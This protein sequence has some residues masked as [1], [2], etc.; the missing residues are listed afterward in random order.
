MSTAPLRV[1]LLGL[2]GFGNTVL[3]AL[4]ADAR[5]RVVAVFTHRYDG[6]FPYYDE[7][8]L[9]DCCARHGVTC[10]HDVTVGSEAG[11]QRMRSA[12]PDVV[13]V[14]TFKD[15]LREAVLS[16]PRLGVVNLHPSLL[17]RHRGPCPT[18]A[19]LLAGDAWSGVTAH[20]AGSGVDDG[21]I[22][23][24][25]RV[26][27]ADVPTDG[28]L[29]RRLAAVAAAMVPDLISL[30]QNGARP[31]GAPQDPSHATHA[32]RPRPED[33]F[34]ELV[35]SADDLCRRVRALTPLPGTSIA[36]GSGRVPVLSC[37]RLPGSAAPVSRD[38]GAIDVQLGSEAV[39][40]FTSRSDR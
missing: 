22:I 21:D 18:Q 7:Q 40:L 25:R 27:I 12:S 6:P 31:A 17:P 37:R 35:P 4:L 10:H 3:E 33:G 36:T 19:A 23:L 2:T 11:L 38:S 34:L 1:V 26:A 13:L 5:V 39:R 15:I 9:I 20:Y 30:W 29:R 24:Q 16:V 28:E 14:A 32:P 8:S